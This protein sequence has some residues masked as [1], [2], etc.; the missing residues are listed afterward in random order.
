[1]FRWEHGRQNGGYSKLKLIEFRR[2]RFDLYLLRFPEGAHV[3]FH[4]DPAPEGFEHHRVNITLRHADRGGLTLIA[5]QPELGQLETPKYRYE[6]RRW[7][8]FRPDTHT[9]MMTSVRSGSVLLLSFGWI[10]KSTK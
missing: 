7:Y 8:R 9:H 4:R 1:M 5:R 3:P 10:T 6:D 2:F